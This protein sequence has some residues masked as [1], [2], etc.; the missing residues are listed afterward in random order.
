MKEKNIS[1]YVNENQP[2][3][4]IENDIFNLLDSMYDEEDK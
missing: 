3:E 2:E 1:K 4:I